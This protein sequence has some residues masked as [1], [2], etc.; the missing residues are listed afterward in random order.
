MA[1]ADDA[2][3]GA[4]NPASMVWAGNRFDIG[5]DLFSPKREISRTGSGGS[6]RP[7]R[8]AVDSGSNL[9]L[10]PGIRLQPA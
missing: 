3:G 7:R 6:G 9:F 10:H 5:V 2:F 8:L 1:I 4:N